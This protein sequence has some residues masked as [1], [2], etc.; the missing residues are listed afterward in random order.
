MGRPKPRIIAYAPGDLEGAGLV[1]AASK[2][3]A[4]GVLDLARGFNERSL[5]E[6]LKRLD[7]RLGRP[8]GLRVAASS[9]SET[10]LGAAPPTLETI[11]VVEE[12]AVDWT[13]AFEIVRKSGRRARAEVTSRGS[14][15]LAE[16]A[17]AE[18]LIVAG[19][20]AGGIG[21]DDSSFIL[22]QGVLDRVEIPVWVRGGIG[23]RVSAGCV[24][25]GA[26]GVVLDGALLLARESPLP[27]SSR[28]RIARWDGSES[29]A[30]G[31]VDGPRIRVFVPPGSPALERLRTS[32]SGPPEVWLAAV[33]SEVGWRPEQ[34]WPVG[35]DSALSGGLSRRNVTAGGIIQAGRTG[36]RPGAWPTLKPLGRSPKALRWRPRSGRSTRSSR[37]R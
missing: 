5:I 17:G 14:A 16:G 32:A 30:I 36:N 20:E 35:Q 7:R 8:F 13:S 29:S 33:R 18:G 24:A 12:D 11:I 23:P 27:D 31:P 22:L 28:G 2:A 1:A 19:H 25:A 26:A 10:W 37:G 4:L 21:S 3:A 15:V 34:A 9:V 6:A